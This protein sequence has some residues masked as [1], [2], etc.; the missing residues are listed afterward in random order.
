MS[1]LKNL[2]VQIYRFSLSWSRIL[3]TGYTNRI[4]KDGIKFYN[5][6]ID[7]LLANGI[8]PM[9]TLCHWDTPQPLEELGGF[10]NALI[11]EIF[12]QYAQIVF[13]HFGDRVK[14]WA[15]FNEPDV[16]CLYGYE[17]GIFAPGV[18][19]PGIGNYLC[20]HNILKAHSRVYHLY[21]TQ[22]FPTWKGTFFI[23]R[24]K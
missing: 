1:L 8:N 17:S 6:L 15:T 20:A 12:V 22:F 18:K 19:A 11:V 13:E 10:T 23:K 5:K 9:V 14:L 2:G 4:N 3:P 7:E 21:R 24:L 16:L